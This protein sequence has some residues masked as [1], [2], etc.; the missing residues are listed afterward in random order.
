MPITGLYHPLVISQS[1]TVAS[2]TIEK[3][4]CMSDP[5][6]RRRLPIGAA[7]AGTVIP[8]L[9]RSGETAADEDHAFA[10]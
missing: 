3:E 2:T 1:E 6:A 10:T 5:S 7:S 4:G 8:S 9:S